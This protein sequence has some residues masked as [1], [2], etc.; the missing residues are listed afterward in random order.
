MPDEIREKMILVLEIDHEGRFYASSEFAWV[1]TRS[2]LPAY[3]A[4]R[5]EAGSLVFQYEEDVVMAIPHD[6]LKRSIV[7]L[8]IKSSE[9]VEE[10][11]E[12]VES[13]IERITTGEAVC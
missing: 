11:D 1:G 10:T 4:K 6:I 2:E 7:K 8:V 13:H 12:D 5:L 3:L 9:F